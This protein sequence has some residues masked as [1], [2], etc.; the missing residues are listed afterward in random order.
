MVHLLINHNSP[1]QLAISVQKACSWHVCSL[2]N[3]HNK[4]PCPGSLY[5]TF[6][7][8]STDTQLKLHSRDWLSS[9]GKHSFR[10][11]VPCSLNLFENTHT[12]IQNSADSSN[13]I[14]VHPWSSKKRQDPYCAEGVDL[15]ITSNLSTGAT[16]IIH[17][18][19]QIHSKQ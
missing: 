17:H 3:R 14:P 9:Q 10:A 13:H 19:Q 16:V 4:G 2:M 15:S 12:C 8:M 5:F 11:D 1:S 7:D 6:R 18:E